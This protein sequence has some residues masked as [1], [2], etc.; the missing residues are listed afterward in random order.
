MVYVLPMEVAWW[1]LVRCGVVAA[2]WVLMV[3][4]KPELVGHLAQRAGAGLNLTW[5]NV[6]AAGDV[7]AEGLAPLGDAVRREVKVADG[8]VPVNWIQTSTPRCRCVLEWVVRWYIT[9]VG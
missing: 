3:T 8:L 1:W 9:C 5:L 2:S 4:T 6:E 7:T